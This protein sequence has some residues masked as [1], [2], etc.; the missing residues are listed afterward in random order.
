[1]WAVAAKDVARTGMATANGVFHPLFG[2][3]EVA[4]ATEKTEGGLVALVVIVGCIMAVVKC[5]KR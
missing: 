4:R 1:M 3:Q 2:L 5:S